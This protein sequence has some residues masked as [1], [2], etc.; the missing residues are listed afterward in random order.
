MMQDLKRNLGA[1]PKVLED[2]S[3]FGNQVISSGEIEKLTV[4]TGENGCVWLMFERTNKRNFS[5]CFAADEP[6]LDT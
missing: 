1:N 6:K 3:W 4:T 5:M 2:V